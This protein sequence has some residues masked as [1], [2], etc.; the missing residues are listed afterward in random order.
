MLFDLTDQ[1][2]SEATDL[3]YWFD[4]PSPSPLGHHH[5]LWIWLRPEPT[6]RHYDPEVVECQVLS[7]WREIDHLRI[8]HH[9]P[10][11]EHYHF[12]LGWI[13][14]NDRKN[15]LM[16]FYSFGGE[17]Q[18]TQHD[19][20]TLCRFRSPGPILEMGQ[21]NNLAHIFVEEVESVLGLELA[22]WDMAQR[23]GNFRARLCQAPPVPIYGA[24][25]RAVGDHLRPL[26]LDSD[27]IEAQLLHFTDHELLQL[28]Q[29]SHPALPLPTLNE[30][31]DGN[32]IR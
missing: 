32:V 9:W 20:V 24:C 18:I 5:Q 23:S 21:T 29:A 15:R 8:H 2:G 16:E 17:L 4:A 11:A 27:Q 12:C 14:L 19:H 10:R 28:S 30:L 7:P 31:L 22:A 1:T 3:G 26:H 6:E 13:S 25:L